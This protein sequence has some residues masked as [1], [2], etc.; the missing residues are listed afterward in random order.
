M[1]GLGKDNHSRDLSPL[2]YDEEDHLAK[3]E[4]NR[5]NV[6]KLLMG[7]RKARKNEDRHK[8]PPF[9]DDFKVNKKKLYI[10]SDIRPFKNLDDIRQMDYEIVKYIPWILQ[11]TS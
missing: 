9:S 7:F 8:Y 6:E 2:S 4:H 10:H 11:M 1:R 5:W 3:V